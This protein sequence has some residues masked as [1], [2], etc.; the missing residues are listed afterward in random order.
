MKYIKIALDV[1]S[2][3]WVLC[4]YAFLLLFSPFLFDS[5]DATRGSAWLIFIGGTLLFNA[6]PLL[7]WL[8]RLVSG[9]W[10]S[11][12][13]A[14]WMFAAIVAALWCIAPFGLWGF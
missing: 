1:V 2:A 12:T 3:L 6:V 9:G 4:A 10:F 13:K 5:P 14:R 11:T 7:W 8:Y